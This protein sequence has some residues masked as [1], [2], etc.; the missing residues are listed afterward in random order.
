[1]PFLEIAQFLREGK[2]MPKL[3]ILENVL[4]LVHTS[5]KTTTSP[6]DCVLHGEVV[7]HGVNHQIELA[8][9]KRYHLEIIAVYGNSFGLPFKRSRVLIMLFRQDAFKLEDVTKLRKRF[10]AE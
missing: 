5:K 3:V 2:R 6:L 10:L 1:M 8:Q 4:G 9:L 7:T